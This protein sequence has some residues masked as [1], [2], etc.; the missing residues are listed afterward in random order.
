[1]SLIYF[2]ESTNNSDELLTFN[3]VQSLVASW[4]IVNPLAA[5][6]F[7]WRPPDRAVS[8]IYLSAVFH[9]DLIPDH[10]LHL[11]GETG[12]LG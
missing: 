9:S 2:R 11:A 10:L 12:S 8:S 5:A 6:V 4:D 3:H 1:M 7:W